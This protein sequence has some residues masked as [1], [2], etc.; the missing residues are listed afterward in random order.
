[1]KAQSGFDLTWQEV[2][3][4][5]LE[6]FYVIEGD[7]DQIIAKRYARGNAGVGMDIKV[8]FL[9]KLDFSR[10]IAI[11]EEIQEETGI[12]LWVNQIRMVN[13]LRNAFVHNYPRGNKGFRYKKGHICDDLK[14]KDFFEDMTELFKK[15]STALEKVK[16]KQ[17]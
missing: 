14:I 3:Y 2:M 12:D 15:L 13:N 5:V 17:E 8:V 10:K 1:M 7:I 4:C 11:L 6:V 16:A 9:S